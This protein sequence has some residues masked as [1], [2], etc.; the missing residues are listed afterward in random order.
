MIFQNCCC[1]HVT[2]K[3]LRL[4]IP[5]GH[6]EHRKR[7]VDERFYDCPWSVQVFAGRQGEVEAELDRALWFQFL[8]PQGLCTVEFSQ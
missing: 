4:T 3:E 7:H 2:R 5:L 8:G 6:L 1:E